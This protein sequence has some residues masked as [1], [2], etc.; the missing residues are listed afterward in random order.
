MNVT[1]TAS[2]TDGD[3]D[4]ATV[5]V[6]RSSSMDHDVASNSSIGLSGS[7][8]TVTVSFTNLNSNSKKSYPPYYVVVEVS[9]DGGK[10]DKDAGNSS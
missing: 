3:L 5:T 6:Y 10:T 8:D 9:D 1:F 2:D 7:T 4:D